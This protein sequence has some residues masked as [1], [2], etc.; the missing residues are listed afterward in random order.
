MK[1]RGWDVLPQCSILDQDDKCHPFAGLRAEIR[2][3][4]LR[5][6]DFLLEIKRFNLILKELLTLMALRMI[7]SAFH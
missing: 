6:N 3:V 5:L 4:M 2:R 7:Y 1:R